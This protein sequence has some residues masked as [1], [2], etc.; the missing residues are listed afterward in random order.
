MF[1]SRQVFGTAGI[2]GVMEPGTSNLND[3]VIIQTTQ[4]LYEYVSQ[5]FP[6][7][8]TRG[9]VVGYDARHNSQRYDHIPP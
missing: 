4:G 6:D 2:R 3:L 5:C 1:G 9:I 8:K 7:L